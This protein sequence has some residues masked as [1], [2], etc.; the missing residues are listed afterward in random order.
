VWGIYWVGK[1]IRVRVSAR[2]LWGMVRDRGVVGNILG[3]EGKGIYWIGN[4]L[5]RE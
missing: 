2:A 3:R 1:E 4:I 5:G